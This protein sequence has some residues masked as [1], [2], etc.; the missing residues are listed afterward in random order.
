MSKPWASVLPEVAAVEAEKESAGARVSIFNP[1]ASRLLGGVAENKEKL[2]PALSAALDAARETGEE[3]EL[4]LPSLDRS[5][6]GYG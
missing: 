1:E 6:G 2:P 4:P 5:Q 3:P